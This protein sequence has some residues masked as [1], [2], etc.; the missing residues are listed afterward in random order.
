MERGIDDAVLERAMRDELEREPGVFAEGFGV[1]RGR[2]ALANVGA[3][4]VT[5]VCFGVSVFAAVRFFGVGTI[6]EKVLWSTVFL[7]ALI[8]SL[9]LKV[10]FWLQMARNA[11]LREVKRV[12][13]RLMQDGRGG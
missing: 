6:E 2:R 1:F 3:A 11:V 8:L 12:E 7:G 4:V 9:A 13:L 10:Y 5:F